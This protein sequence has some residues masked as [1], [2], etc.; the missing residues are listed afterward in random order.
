MITDNIVS[1]KM[2]HLIIATAAAFI[3]LKYSP[4]SKWQRIL[5]IFGYFTSF[6]YAVISQSYSIGIVMIF[7]VSGMIRPK[8]ERR[9]YILI[10]AALTLM[11]Q[12]T[13][14]SC[15]IAIAFALTFGFEF[16]VLT[17]DK[18]TKSDWLIFIISAVIF[19]F[20]LALTI[21]QLI[22]PSDILTTLEYKRIFANIFYAIARILTVIGNFTDAFLPI[23]VISRH[24]WL[25]NAVTHII[26]HVSNSSFIVLHIRVAIS[27]CFMF[28]VFFMIL[29]T[30]VAV[31]FFIIGSIGLVF[32][33]FFIYAPYIRQFGHI[34]IVVICSLW[35]SYFYKPYVFK[36]D[37]LNIVCA[38][39]ENKKGMF[40]SFLIAIQ[41]IAALAAIT[42]HAKYQ[43]SSS[44]E[45]AEYIKTKHL[46][47][48]P[49]AADVDCATAAIS[50]YLG[51]GF[52]YPN[53]GR[54]SIYAVDN[55]KLLIQDLMRELPGSRYDADKALILKEARKYMLLKQTSILLVLN[56]DLPDYMI[57][58][59]GLTHIKSFMNSVVETEQYR[60][61]IMKY[62]IETSS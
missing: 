51:K 41:L 20:G 16:L 25:T 23:P 36:S 55:N 2:V 4:F 35:L 24:F 47:D 59:N 30:P 53:S 61:F 12:G 62:P 6:E 8:Q 14:Y 13:A 39:F 1:I 3:F 29:R 46:D 60:L 18:R 37:I 45:T 34:F 17:K 26:E 48:L 31:F 43:F 57:K 50:V 22:P 58:Q 40:L 32:F 10:A 44:N 33:N 27:L 7:V 54:S 5:F 42:L 28:A 56:Y 19:I 21:V 49:I 38:F 15:V 9:N 11:C 52:Y